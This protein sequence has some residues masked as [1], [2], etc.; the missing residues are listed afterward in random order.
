MQQHLTETVCWPDSSD[1]PEKTLHAMLSNIGCDVG[2]EDKELEKK[3]GYTVSHLRSSNNASLARKLRLVLQLLGPDP[4][5]QRAAAP[6][7]VH[8]HLEKLFSI[9]DAVQPSSLQHSQAAVA[10]ATNTAFR[11]VKVSTADRQLM[12]QCLSLF[13][14]EYMRKLRQLERQATAQMAPVLIAQPVLLQQTPD[15]PYLYHTVPGEQKQY[16]WVRSQA[17]AKELM[18]WLQKE[19]QLWHAANRDAAVKYKDP[20]PVLQLLLPGR[21]LFGKPAVPP[22]QSDD[23]RQ[24]LQQHLA[25]KERLRTTFASTSAMQ[26]AINTLR[27]LSPSVADAPRS[28][29]GQP[30]TATVEAPRAIA[31]F[32]F[33]VRPG[34]PDAALGVPGKPKRRVTVHRILDSERDPLV[35]SSHAIPV[36]QVSLGGYGGNRLIA[37]GYKV[38]AGGSGRGNAMHAMSAR[39]AWSAKLLCLALH[40]HCTMRRRGVDSSVKQVLIKSTIASSPHVVPCLVGN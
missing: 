16:D 13:A 30:E 24:K 9:L 34:A 37:A 18:D 14:E 35:V 26:C 27:S 23:V 22:R 15:N 32:Q 39:H 6:P 7:D 10:A 21:C 5:A 11:Q 1:S 2:E 25:N 33:S 38:V 36:Q 4:A 29:V 8:P 17:T 28:S 19:A 31:V 40:G 3:L 20:P 12:Q